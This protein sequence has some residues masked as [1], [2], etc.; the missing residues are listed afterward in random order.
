MP[1]IKITPAQLN[2]IMSGLAYIKE[3]QKDLLEATEKDPEYYNI[4][5]SRPGFKVATQ[6]RNNI[7][8]C[9]IIMDLFGLLKDNDLTLS[10]D[11]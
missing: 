7:Q 8:D 1:T 10:L 11:K 3:R 4:N 9:N 2:I 5:S 6:Y